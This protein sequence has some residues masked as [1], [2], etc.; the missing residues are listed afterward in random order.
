V[1]FHHNIYTQAERNSPSV[2]GNDNGVVDVVNN[3]IHAWGT[4]GS[5]W[6]SD[7][8]ITQGNL[9]ANLYVPADTSE[10]AGAVTIEGGAAVYSVGNRVPAGANANGTATERFE[11]PAVYEQVAAQAAV[12]V[13]SEAGAFPR[14][15]T[16]TAFLEQ[17]E[18]DINSG[19]HT[20]VLAPAPVS[21]L[22][23]VEVGAVWV[24]LG[25]HAT[26]DDGLSGRASG[27]DLRYSTTPIDESNFED[28]SQVLDLDPP[29]DPGSEEDE[30]VT[31]LLPE[32]IYYFAIVVEDEQGN[33]SSVSPH[34]SAETLVDDS[35]LDPP[36][37]A[38]GARFQ[39]DVIVVSWPES[40]DLRVVGY[41]VYRTREGDSEIR[42]TD[43]PT[44]ETSYSDSDVTGGQA[45]F[46][47]ITGIDAGARESDHSASTW[48]RASIG[49]P[50]ALTIDRV[51]PN[52]VKSNAVFRF[53]I[54]E[55]GPGHPGGMRV[56]IDL[57][58]VA[59]RRV[60]RVVDD[61]FL[62]GVR[63]VSWSLAS[64]EVPLSSGLYVG[65]LKAGGHKALT[66]IAIVR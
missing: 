27:Y 64:A 60:S 35:P 40:N 53:Q 4:V 44:T 47:R 45:Y 37:E 33:R 62:P 59:G 32:T 6:Y 2:D 43:T 10:A 31:G 25:W 57:F 26:G 24:R 17:L 51:Y 46:Y 52:P 19:S 11:A 54:P 42:L 34:V 29:E 30:T 65:M 49:L 3:I 22:E 18:S 23:I 21:D 41:H 38:P 48:I 20:D 61:Y 66:R 12:L 39:D 36:E 15:A 16:D 7:Q 50:P 9:I 28:A 14:D 56:T 13:L 8:S 58:N 5:H 63:E 1:T 55:F